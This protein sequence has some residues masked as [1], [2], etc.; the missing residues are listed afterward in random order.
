MQ[1]TGLGIKGESSGPLR[2]SER[3]TQEV[4]KRE[5]KMEGGRQG[6]MWASSA[7]L[8]RLK[9]QRLSIV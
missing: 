2:R 8:A 7:A 5:V 6:E 9:G 4:E 1:K 3:E